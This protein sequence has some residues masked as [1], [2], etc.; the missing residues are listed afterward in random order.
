MYSNRQDRLLAGQDAND[1][2]GLAGGSTSK[3]SAGWLAGR[4]GCWLARTLTLIRVLLEALQVNHARLEGWPAG[5][6]Q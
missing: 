6:G 2:K 4:A 1:N 5:L 3:L